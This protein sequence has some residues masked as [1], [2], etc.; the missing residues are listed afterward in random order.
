MGKKLLQG[1]AQH[2]IAMADRTEGRPP[3]A[4]SLG[5]ALDLDLENID[6]QNRIF[7]QRVRERHF[8]KQ[9]AGLPD[10]KQCDENPKEALAC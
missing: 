3:H 6:E 4:I 2:Y 9:L 10:E 5:G 8:K 7:T 1:S